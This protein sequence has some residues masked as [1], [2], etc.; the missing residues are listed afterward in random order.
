MAG[1]NGLFPTLSEQF[2]RDIFDQSLQ[3]TLLVKGHHYENLTGKENNF[4]LLEQS[5]LSHLY[6]SFDYLKDKNSKY[7]PS[8]SPYK[9]I[10][11]KGIWY[12]VA[13]DNTKI[14]TFSFT[15]INNINQSN[16]QFNYESKIER[17]LYEEDGIWFGNVQIEFIL[18]ISNEVSG[19]FKRRKLIANQV[20][21]K[22]LE[23]GDLIISTK[24]GH[25]NQVLPIVRYWMPHIQIISPD[26][27]K[28]EM[29]TLLKNYLNDS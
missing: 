18:K 3:A 19:Y 13:L 24:V 5:I 17:Q 26:K 9:L 11:H 6:I 14:K 25:L 27:A 2:F 20:I 16:T 12:L 23:N 29:Y 7:Y 4:R 15:K 21:E 22:E 28:N 8:V 10:N 1:I